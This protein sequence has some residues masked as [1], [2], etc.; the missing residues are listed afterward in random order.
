MWG[1]DPYATRTAI[2][3]FIARHLANFLESIHG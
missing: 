1:V 3:W 2:D